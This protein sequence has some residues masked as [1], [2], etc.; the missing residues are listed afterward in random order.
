MH[1]QIREHVDGPGGDTP[2]AI[3]ACVLLGRV[4]G[5][6]SSHL[7][8]RFIFIAFDVSCVKSALLLVVPGNHGGEIVVGPLSSR[9]SGLHHEAEE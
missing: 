2:K 9:D 6:S 1:D 7:C 8:R 4:F 3:P 5:L